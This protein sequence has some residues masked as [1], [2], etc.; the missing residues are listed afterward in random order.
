M[1]I[2]YNFI[3]YGKAGQM[4]LVGIPLL[5]VDGNVYTFLKVW[6]FRWTSGYSDLY[7]T[8]VG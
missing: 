3:P 7:T 6:V 4:V 5:Q 2:S 1:N 8:F